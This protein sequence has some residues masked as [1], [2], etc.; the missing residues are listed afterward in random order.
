MNFNYSYRAFLITSLL[1][2]IFFLILYSIKLSSEPEEVYEKYD[3]AYEDEPVLT[4]EEIEELAASED[5]LTAIET[6]RAYNEAEKF[7]KEAQNANEDLSAE[8][9]ERIMNELEAAIKNT[10]GS[11]SES[12]E[13]AKEKIA[14]TKAQIEKSNAQQESGSNGTSRKT[15]ISYRLVDRKAITLPNPVYTC[16]ASGIIVLS[17]EVNELGMITKATFNRGM[18]TTSNGCLIDSAM[19]YANN[20]RFS[21]KAGKDSQL[22]TITYNFPGQ[23]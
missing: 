9:L 11:N 23:G 20:S 17:I 22:G 5:N 18:S 19:E 10:E 3:V 4:E 6:N 13:K 21:R 14:E 16:N 8:D 12:I 2:G 15:T 1:F 7:L